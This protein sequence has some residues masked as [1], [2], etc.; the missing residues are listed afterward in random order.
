M[1]TEVVVV[2]PTAQ[3]DTEA[4][5]SAALAEHHSLGLAEDENGPDR[6]RFVIAVLLARR[7]VRE[8]EIVVVARSEVLLT[9]VVV[10]LER[11]LRWIQ[12]A[13]LRQRRRWNSVGL[14]EW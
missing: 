8:V 13:V 12:T 4:A 10:V 14:Q 11:S 6:E 5:L 3:L 2:P 9:A 7:L 1:G